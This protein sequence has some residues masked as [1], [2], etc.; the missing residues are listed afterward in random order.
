M[1][2]K[3]PYIKPRK[4]GEPITLI[5]APNGGWIV[6]VRSSQMGVVDDCLGAF[7]CAAEMLEALA[8]GLR[9]GDEG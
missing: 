6:N 7:G 3:K 1:M 9:D 2:S 5:P 8:D 4:H